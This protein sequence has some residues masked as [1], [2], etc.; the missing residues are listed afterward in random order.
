MKM[1][2]KIGVTLAV[3]L[4]VAVITL[5]ITGQW[6]PLVNSVLAWICGQVKV[7]P[8]YQLP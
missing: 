2:Q 5:Y 7:S 1:W 6:K 8:P 3:I 4:I